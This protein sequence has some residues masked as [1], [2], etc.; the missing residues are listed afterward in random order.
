M[1]RRPRNIVRFLVAPPAPPDSSW[2]WRGGG[3]E[4]ARAYLSS[5]PTSESCR[6]QSSYYSSATQDAPGTS[7]TS[8]PRCVPCTPADG[9]TST[10]MQGSGPWHPWP[11]GSAEAQT[12]RIV[13]PSHEGKP[14][15]PSPRSGPPQMPASD[16]TISLV[17]DPGTSQPDRLPPSSLT[18]PLA[19]GGASREADSC[20]CGPIF[21]GGEVREA[22]RGN[23]PARRRCGSSAL[24]APRPTCTPSSRPYD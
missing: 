7:R 20:E 8:P 24:L 18:S 13:S 9:Y 15:K 5:K 22:G 11:G 3:F 6:L 12:R 17:P 10:E 19:S 2:R 16:A 21:L 4:E 14:P 1:L 23:M